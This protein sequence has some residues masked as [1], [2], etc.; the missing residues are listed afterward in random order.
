MTLISIIIPI[1][2]SERYLENTINSIIN[3]T[4]GFENIELILVDDN[5]SDNSR[6]IVKK[7]A[8]KYDNVVYYFSKTNHGYPGFGRNKG[9]EIANSE[10]IMFCDNDDEY[11]SE[12]CEK[13]YDAIIR[14]DADCVSCNKVKRDHITEVRHVDK[15]INGCIEEPGVVSI[16]G[17]DINYFEDISIWN[18]IF[19]R[20]L[21]IKNNIKYIE[22]GLGE[23]FLFATE[24][25]FNCEKLIFL[26][27]YFGYYW[28]VHEDSL[29][30]DCNENKVRQLV[31]SIYVMDSLVKKYNKEKDTFFYL[32]FYLRNIYRFCI[33][34]KMPTS[35]LKKILS[36]ISDYE[37]NLYG[38]PQANE[39]W[40]SI[41]N[42]F[43]YKKH[44]GIAALIINIM[45]IS[46]NSDLLRRIFRLI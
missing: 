34:A 22:N 4:I 9:I 43:V 11:D 1:Y 32:K 26:E 31:D 24:C 18:K 28:D 23:D 30:H 12:Q 37:N 2:N 33:D 10:Y 19:K 29:F 35:H 7:F 13:L 6:V 41:I 21:L 20:D 36:E 25:F 42:T 39:R 46:K 14:Y 3:Q 27:D 8:E 45:I 17:E 5:S 44:I 38:S 40:V 15:Y 16:Y